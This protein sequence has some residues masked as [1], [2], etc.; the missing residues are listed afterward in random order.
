M[1]RSREVQAS[2]PRLLHCL[3]RDVT[4]GLRAVEGDFQWI[5][6]VVHITENDTMKT[7]DTALTLHRWPYGLE[8]QALRNGLMLRPRQ[9]ARANWAK[10]F[11]RPLRSSD[12]LAATRDLTNQFDRKEWQW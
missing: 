9:K 3:C 12:D 5:D 6:F 11:R 4:A 1:F 2:P 7:T 8:V 10:A